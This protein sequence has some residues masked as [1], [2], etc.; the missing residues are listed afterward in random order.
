MKRY[1]KGVVLGL[2][3]VVAG[4]CATTVQAVS[5]APIVVQGAMEVE[6]STL[7]KALAH[8]RKSTIGGWTFWK[9]TLDGY[10][11]VVSKT[12]I[13]M[14]NAAAATT[15]AALS[16]HPRAIINQ[17]TAGGHD[18]N[19]RVHDIVLGRETLNLGSFKTPARKRGE[20][21]DV[22]AWE[23]MDI[24]TEES[25]TSEKIVDKPIRRFMPAPMLYDIAM[26]HR[27]DYK[28]GQVVPGVIGSADVWNNEIDRID[29]LH[30]RFGTSAEEMEAA[31]VAQVADQF[32]IPYL[33]V[34]ILSN[35]A[36][37][38]G[39]YDATTAVECQEYVLT[40]L[41][42]YIAQFKH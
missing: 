17:G 33:A 7:V 27:S 13:G 25:D 18:P 21:A 26:H 5:Q 1:V 10:P 32:G 40:L 11:V 9:G 37:N 20:G 38:D 14:S 8:V 35:N 22:L 28:K 12:E 31:S 6:T 30:K 15:I 42:A 39:E 2:G 34:R 19:L 41:K 3:V 4:M 23:P 24:L 29:N 36:T 16:F